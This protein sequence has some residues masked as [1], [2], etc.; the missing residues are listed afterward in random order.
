MPL[1]M[2]FFNEN[3]AMRNLIKRFFFYYCPIEMLDFS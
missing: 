1:P 2:V 3:E